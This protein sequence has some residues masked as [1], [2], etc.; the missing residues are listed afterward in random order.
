[1]LMFSGILKNFVVFEGCDGS[2]TSTQIALLRKRF[3]ESPGA[4]PELCATAQP[5]DG[6]IGR[7][8][9]RALKGSPNL[10]PETLAL[11]FAA[12]R[13]EHLRAAGGIIEDCSRGRLVVCDRYVMSSLVYQ[14]IACGEDLPLALNSR[15]PAPELTLFFDIDPREAQQRMAGRASRDIFENLD[16]QTKA[17]ERY[18]RA[19]DEARLAGHDLRVIDAAQSEEEVAR[20]VW[21]CLSKLPIMTTNG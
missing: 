7:L 17:R 11:L 5:T 16:F 13:E 6:E 15:F 14:G 21:S 4:L 3:A 19:V 12:D 10:L 18:L 1:M 2:G 8:I 9:R 20:Q